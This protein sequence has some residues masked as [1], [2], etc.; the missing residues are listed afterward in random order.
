MNIQ[1]AKGFGTKQKKNN[2]NQMV[3]GSWQRNIK[4]DKTQ[5]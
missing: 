5:Q 2:K 4:Q 1:Q 3:A